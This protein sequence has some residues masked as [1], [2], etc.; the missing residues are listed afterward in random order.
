[1]APVDGVDK[2]RFDGAEGGRMEVLG[3]FE[4][5]FVIENNEFGLV[6][7]GKCR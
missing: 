5:V 7:R 4:F 1:M 3:E 6:W 2:I